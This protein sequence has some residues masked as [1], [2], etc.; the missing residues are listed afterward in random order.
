[1]TIYSCNTMVLPT[2]QDKIAHST[3]EGGAPRLVVTSS[4][5]LSF[6]HFQSTNSAITTS[7][8]CE[9]RIKRTERKRHQLLVI[10]VYLST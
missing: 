4:A 5:K 1:M 6:N 7:I 2:T 9:A 3:N 8:R 10:L